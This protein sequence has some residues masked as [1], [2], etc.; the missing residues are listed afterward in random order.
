MPESGSDAPDEGPDSPFYAD[1]AL[2]R[3]QSVVSLLKMLRL[4]EIDR[5]MAPLRYF[6][7]GWL[8]QDEEKEVRSMF[9][10]KITAGVIKHRKLPMKYIAYLMLGASVYKI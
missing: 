10:R 8:M 7:L 5:N 3:M 4:K 9:C 2:L 1:K 6:A